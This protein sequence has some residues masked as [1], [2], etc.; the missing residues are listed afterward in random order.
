MQVE[1]N[2]PVVFE[3]TKH[4]KAWQ[5]IATRI[6][7]GRI[8]SVNSMLMVKFKALR[9]YHNNCAACEYANTL[10][11]YT[12][13]WQNNICCYYPLSV[14]SDNDCLDGQYSRLRVLLSLLSD[15]NDPSIRES[16]VQIAEQIRDWL[17]KDGVICR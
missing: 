10:D 11:R 9:D 7:N 14:S 5:V 6:A 15:K 13:K 3:H 12:P 17:V 16:A 8:S 4:K 1:R 2:T